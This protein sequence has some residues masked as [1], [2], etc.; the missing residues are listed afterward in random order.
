LLFVVS[1]SQVVYIGTGS[2][3][4][5]VCDFVNGELIANGSVSSGSGPSFLALGPSRSVLYAV[6][7]YDDGLE[8]FAIDASRSWKLT[9]LNRVSC[10]SGPA[11]LSVDGRGN[12]I[13]AANYGSGNY[14]IFPILSDGSI[15]SKP[16]F[17]AADSGHGPDPVR[18]Q[19]PHPHQFRFDPSSRFVFVSDLGTDKIMQWIYDP[20]EGTMRPNPRSAALSVKSGS[21]PRHLAFHPTLFVVYGINELVSSINVY[22]YDGIAGTLGPIVQSL[23]SLPPGANPASN[24][25]GEI[26]VSPD[27]RFV[28]ASNRGNNSIAVFKVHPIDGFL[29]FVSFKPCGGLT[30]RF[31]TL[32]PFGDYLLVANQDSNNIVVFSV[33]PVTGAI[34][35][36]KSSLSVPSPQCI[37]FG[38]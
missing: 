32:A 19:S 23:T 10:V 5:Y 2:N 37:L 6:N 36:T 4:I 29:S 11:H 21:G 20:D 8:A 15:A 34:T 14:T 30:P 35:E 33:D 26:Q 1:V 27:G 3:S 17:V 25:G 24:T 18:Q 22:H 31:F 16:S 28:Y 38:N 9:L 12:F 13:G 7:E